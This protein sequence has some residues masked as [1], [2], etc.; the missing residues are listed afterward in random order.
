[1]STANTPSLDFIRNVEPPEKIYQAALHCLQTNEPFLAV[2]LGDGES[3]YLNELEDGRLLFDKMHFGGSRSLE[4]HKKLKELLI[5]AIQNADFIGGQVRQSS[6]YRTS[7][8]GRDLI[9]HSIKKYMS[10]KARLC[11]HSYHFETSLNMLVDLVRAAKDI[12]LI[13]THKL[14]TRFCTVFNK[15]P[16]S[17]HILLIPGEHKFVKNRTNFKPLIWDRFHKVEHQIK[18][19][20]SPGSLLLYGAG[21]GGKVF[22]AMFKAHGG[23]AIDLGSVMDLWNG[24]V[25]R[26]KWARRQ[27]GVSVAPLLQKQFMNCSPRE[28]MNE[29]KMASRLLK[30]KE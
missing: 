12:V 29:A 6:S 26:S 18:N 20:A 22:G 9:N 11:N 19:L 8:G 3:V 16:S 14:R 27:G 7:C 23:V 25:T 4:D 5:I 30:T 17:V 15:D 1:M 24:R 28:W 2:R 13:S 21:A 10:P